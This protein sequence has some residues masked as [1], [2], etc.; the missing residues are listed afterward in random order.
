MFTSL[1]D[2]FR[3]LGELPPTPSTKFKPVSTKAAKG[4]I[5]VSGVPLIIH[6]HASYTL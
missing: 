2:G 5:Q 4:D 1:L 6:Q 3:L